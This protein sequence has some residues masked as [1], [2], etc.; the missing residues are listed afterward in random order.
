ME[1][2]EHFLSPK[3]YFAG[4]TKKEWVFLHHTA[5]WDNPIQTI[6][7]WNKDTQGQIATEF[8]L[9]GPSIKNK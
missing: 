4:P 3:Q 2:K 6:D 5:G 9:G 7:I 1:I 8:V